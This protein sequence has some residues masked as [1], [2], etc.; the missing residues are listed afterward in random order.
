MNYLKVINDS[1]SVL[2]PEASN[3]CNDKIIELLVLI[4]PGVAISG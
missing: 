2:K 3:K 4:K 1:E